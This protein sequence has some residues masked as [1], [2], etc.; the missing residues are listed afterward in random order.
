MA[1]SASGEDSKSSG[2]NGDQTD[3]SYPDSGA[4]YIFVY[5]PDSSTWNQ[6]AYLK[7]P[8]TDSYDGLGYSIAISANS[9]ILAAGAPLENSRATGV[10]GDQED[11]S[12]YWNGA[13]FIY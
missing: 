11:N 7:E 6:Q 9:E 13:V 4:A 5:S 10:G 3:D 2:I 1:A 12:G 8:N